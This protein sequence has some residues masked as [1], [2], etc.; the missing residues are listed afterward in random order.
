[1]KR[2][3]ASKR[4]STPAGSGRRRSKASGEVGG[5]RESRDSREGRRGRQERDGRE[6]QGGMPA[7]QHLS[8]PLGED[9]IYDLKVGDVVFLSGTVITA[10]DEAHVKLLDEGCPI[11]LDMRG[12]AVY[13]CGPLVKRE[14]R[15]WRVLSAGPTSSYRVEG[16]EP[17]FLRRFPARMLIGKGGMGRGTLDALGKYRAVYASFTGG[18]GALASKALKQVREVFF[19]EELGPAQAVWVFEAR[20]LGPLVVTMDA[21]GNSLYE[22][23]GRRS[24]ENLERILERMLEVRYI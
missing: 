15:K 8:T 4:D 23:V 13:H 20:D 7:A 24:R 21:H 16:M 12:A 14:A 3:G 19:L 18:A 9:T 6:G 1:M 2:C 10:R 11:G 5:G 17:S 22:D